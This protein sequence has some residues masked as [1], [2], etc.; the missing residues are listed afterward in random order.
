MVMCYHGLNSPDQSKRRKVL[1]T[2]TNFSPEQI[3]ELKAIFGGTPEVTSTSPV[4]VPELTLKD[5][6]YLLVRHTRL[7]DEATINRCYAAI[8]KAF[9]EPQPDAQV[10][11][12]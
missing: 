12:E 8:D 4:E 11:H 7:P 3:A 10:P 5:V 9:D 6:L 2:V 1:Q